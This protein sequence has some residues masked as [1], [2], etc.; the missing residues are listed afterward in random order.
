MKPRYVTCYL[1]T[2]AF[3]EPFHP[4]LAEFRVLMVFFRHFACCEQVIHTHCSKS[5]S[6]HF[7]KQGR[8][9]LQSLRQH[10]PAVLLDSLGFW[11][12]PPEGRQLQWS[13]CSRNAGKSMLQVQNQQYCPTAVVSRTYMDYLLQAAN[14]GLSHKWPSRLRQWFIHCWVHLFGRIGVLYRNL[15]GLI[16]P[17]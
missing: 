3:W 15:Q 17:S 12:L 13:F 9:N 8:G 16:S 14:L 10:C 11:V 1:H 7:P 6:Q 2:W 5:P 4:Q